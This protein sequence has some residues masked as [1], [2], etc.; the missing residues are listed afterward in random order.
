VIRPAYYKVVV[1]GGDRGHEAPRKRYVA[2]EDR[3]STWLAFS[4]ADLRVLLARLRHSGVTASRMR[5]VVCYAD[6]SFSELKRGG[7]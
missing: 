4:R 7:W 1:R 3:V 5:P 2:Q 6:G